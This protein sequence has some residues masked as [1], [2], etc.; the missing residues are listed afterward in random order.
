MLNCEHEV[1]LTQMIPASLYTQWYVHHLHASKCYDYKGRMSLLLT[2]PKVLPMHQSYV[3]LTYDKV[4]YSL[5]GLKIYVIACNY[6]VTQS[7][8]AVKPI[9]FP[10]EIAIYN[11]SH[12]SI[13][14]YKL[15][16]N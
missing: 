12:L 3:T 5:R 6:V 1:G 15:N 13:F 2:K 8:P 9:G 4:S 14:W 16:H 7:L 11:P 10:I